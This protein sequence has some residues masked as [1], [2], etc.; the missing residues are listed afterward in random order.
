MS[1]ALAGRAGIRRLSE[2]RPERSSSVAAGR[3]RGWL[4][5]RGL[6]RLQHEVHLALDGLPTA[7]PACPLPPVSPSKTLYCHHTDLVSVLQSTRYSYTCS[8]SI[9]PEPCVAVPQPNSPVTPTSVPFPAVSPSSQ[10]AKTLP[11]HRAKLTALAGL[12]QA[13]HTRGTTAVP[14][15]PR[16]QPSPMGCRPPHWLT[17]LV[18]S[19]TAG[20]AGRDR[21][22]SHARHPDGTQH[23][24]LP[25][26]RWR[27]LG[28]PSK[29]GRKDPSLVTG[30]TRREEMRRPVCRCRSCGCPCRE[31]CCLDK[32]DC[33]PGAGAGDLAPGIP[34]SPGASGHVPSRSEGA[35]T[36]TGAEVDVHASR[37]NLLQ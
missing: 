11:P 35:G 18:S 24:P 31:G 23:A 3:D 7:Q 27:W 34:H 36:A 37:S 9:H 22:R 10:R 20:S 32:L 21:G 15:D 19:A 29:Q 16:S 4:A 1:E 30:R 8:G 5:P 17:E 33:L 2:Q 12:P 13:C 28:R 6:G 14:S 26:G 25:L